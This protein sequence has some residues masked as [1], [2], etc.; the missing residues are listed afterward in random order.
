MKIDCLAQGRVVYRQHSVPYI[1]GFPQEGTYSGKTTPV[2]VPAKRSLEF[3][4][5]ITPKIMA[6]FWQFSFCIHKNIQVFI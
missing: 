3:E 1:V 4:M 6:Y 5:I 2:P